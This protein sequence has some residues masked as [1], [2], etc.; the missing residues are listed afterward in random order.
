M[1]D[2]DLDRT[3]HTQAKLALDGVQKICKT[4]L[5]TVFKCNLFMSNSV[6]NRTTFVNDLPIINKLRLYSC[7][8]RF[9]EIQETSLKNLI[10]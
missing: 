7:E 9:C 10:Y 8:G 4:Q 5:D 2:N 3:F 1:T 6:E